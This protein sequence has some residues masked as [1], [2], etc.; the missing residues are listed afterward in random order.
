MRFFNSTPMAIATVDR[1]GRIARNNALF[2]NLFHTMLKGDAGPQGRSIRNVIAERDRAALD[3]ALAAAAC[4]QADIAPIDAALAGEAE[5][6]ARFYATPVEKAERDAET[7]IVYAIETTEQRKLQRQFDQSQKMELVGKFAGGIAH[8]FNNVLSSIMMAADFLLID[9][10]QS[11]RSFQDIIQIKHDATRAANL[12]KQLLAFSRQQTLRPE[13]LDLH[14]SLVELREMLQRLIGE[15]I[16][17]NLVDRPKDLWSVQADQTQFEQVVVN[18]AVNAHDA[19]PDGGR[20]SLRTANVSAEQSRQ[21]AYKGLQ[22]GDYVLVEVIDTGTGI[23]AKIRDKVFEPFFTTKEVGKGTG[24]GLSTV[25]GIVKQTGGFVFL[26]STMGE[27]T[28]F[29]IFLP[30]MF[31]GATQAGAAEAPQSAAAEPS[32]GEAA[33]KAVPADDTGSGTILLVEDE[34]GLRKLNARGLASRGYKVLQA[35]N[36]VEAIEVF[37]GHDGKIDVVVSDVVMPEMNGP[38][39]LTQL[40]I[41]DPNVK[42]IF[43]SGY[44]G[45]AFKRTCRKASSTIFSP[46]LSRSSSLSVPSRKP[47]ALEPAAFTLRMICPMIYLARPVA[48]LARRRLPAEPAVTPVQGRFARIVA[49]IIAAYEA[50]IVAVMA[51]DASDFARGVPFGAMFGSPVPIDVIRVG[52]PR[53]D[54]AGV[55]AGQARAGSGAVIVAVSGGGREQEHGDSR[56]PAHQGGPRMP[57]TG[58]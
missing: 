49:A 10:K 27:G 25:Y 15:R 13:V 53:D 30:A 31:R 22:P 45:D 42:V 4:G 41:R 40:R 38:T 51:M 50:D 12:V 8:D 1:N 52:R 14:A 23:P 37:E 2:A 43:V 7:A 33:A 11:D 16:K 57:R 9:H 46:S 32:G 36:G 56:S 34:E 21:F 19:M 48:A 3:A 47:R 54:P 18:L 20:L 55:I 44:A 39:L 28:T 24:L 5:R 17:L 6:W 29:R 26:D 58:G 35:A